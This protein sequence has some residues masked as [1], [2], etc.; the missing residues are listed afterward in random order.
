MGQKHSIG[1]IDAQLLAC[2]SN[3]L[4]VEQG[5][6]LQGGCASLTSADHIDASSAREAVY[7]AD[8][9]QLCLQ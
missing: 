3:S 1:F 4:P 9:F 8:V 6:H 5:Q 7:F 2:L